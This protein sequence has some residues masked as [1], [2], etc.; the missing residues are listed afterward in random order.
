MSDI[1]LKMSPP[2][3]TYINKLEALFDGDPQIAFNVNWS[4]TDPSIDIATNNPD[5][6]AAL[7]K[8]LPTEKT[9]GN[10]TL[11]IS[12]SC[13]T[14]SNLAFKTAK[15][16]FE[17][18]FK[19]NPAFAYVVVPTNV[20]YIPF[21]YVVFKNCVVQFFNDNL[22]DPHGV[23]STLYEN[24]ADEIFEDMQFPNIG[25]AFCT[26]IER[27]LGVSSDNWIG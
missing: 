14:I 23:V 18:A 15:D 13:D 5:K 17:T 19:G 20:Y 2:W 10:V 24:I 16:L 8:L 22:N 11:T 7:L 25:I 1:R 9:F 6:A 12:V 27:S 3:I 26:D 4:A 21:T